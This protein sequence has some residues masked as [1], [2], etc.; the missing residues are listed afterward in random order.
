MRENE[1]EEKVKVKLNKNKKQS[2]PQNKT[3]KTK[4]WNKED[5]VSN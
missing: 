5:E 1:L 2:P 4:K 3:N